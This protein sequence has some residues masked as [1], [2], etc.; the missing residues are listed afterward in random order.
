MV[1]NT[2]GPKF[3]LSQTFLEPTN[4]LNPTFYWSW[5]F[6][7]II[8]LTPKFLDQKFFW[9]QMFSPKFFWT[10]KLFWTQKNF[11]LTFC[12]AQTQLQLSKAEI[13]L[14]SQLWGSTI[15]HTPTRNSS[16]DLFLTNSWLVH[17]LLVTCSKQ[18]LVHNFFMNCAWLV[19]DRLIT[20]SW[21]VLELFM[22]C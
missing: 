13:D 9:T 2:L 4:F 22:T 15:H 16:L 20:C 3:C 8:S 6:W 18:W 1:L 5:F 11:G 7:P 10:H 17:D 19:H 21:L 12:Q 14:L